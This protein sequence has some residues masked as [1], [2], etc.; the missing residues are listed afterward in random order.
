MGVA[1]V[2]ERAAGVVAAVAVCDGC[3]V[4]VEVDVECFDR[5]VFP[6]FLVGPGCWKAGAGVGEGADGTAPVA[7]DL[8]GR[9]RLGFL[10]LGS[11]SDNWR[12]G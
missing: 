1:V 2:L 5:V 4:T 8:S 7:W 9:D 3:A 6:C 12:L 10:V 11:L